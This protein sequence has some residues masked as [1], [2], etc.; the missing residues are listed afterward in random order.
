MKKKRTDKIKISVSKSS[1]NVC[2]VKRQAIQSNKAGICT[3]TIT[4]TSKSGV[5]EIKT[6]Q[7]NF[8]KSGK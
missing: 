5:K 7:I 8:S 6:V 2:K 4:K 3:V 1:K